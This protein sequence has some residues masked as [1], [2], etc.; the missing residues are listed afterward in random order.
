[1]SLVVLW[2]TNY[3]CTRRRKGLVNFNLSGGK[4]L[5]GFASHVK[6]SNKVKKKGGGRGMGGRGDFRRGFKF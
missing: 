1:M 6:F 2:V 5:Y 3:K 4:L